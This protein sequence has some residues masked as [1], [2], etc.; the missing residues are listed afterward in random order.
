MSVPVFVTVT[1]APGT[2]APDGSVTAPKMAAVVACP[3]RGIFVAPAKKITNSVQ[4]P[5]MRIFDLAGIPPPSFCRFSVPVEAPDSGAAHS[6]TG[7]SQTVGG[8]SSP[9]HALG[10]EGGCHRCVGEKFNQ[11]LRGIRIFGVGA[12]A[13][14][15]AHVALEL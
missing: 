5:A 9:F 10:L 15:K 11:G 1:L 13:R 8:T 6:A 2:A 7:T 12:D 14:C 4:L 3:A